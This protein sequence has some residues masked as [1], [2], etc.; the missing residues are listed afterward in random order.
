MRLEDRLRGGDPLC[1]IGRRQRQ[2]AESGLDGAAQA[3]VEANGGGI[4]RQLVDRRAGGS[5]DDLAVS[6]GDENL[7]GVGIGRQPAILQAR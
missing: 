6:L 7:L 1:R 2:A 3:V 4:V 5:I